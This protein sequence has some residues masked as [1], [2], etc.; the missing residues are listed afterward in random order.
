METEY[1]EETIGSSLEQNN[2][3]LCDQIQSLK[4]QMFILT[5]SKKYQ[6]LQDSF[7]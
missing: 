4:E 3:R 7:K 6:A 2:E 1:H 5:K